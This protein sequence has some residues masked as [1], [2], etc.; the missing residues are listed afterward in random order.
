[1]MHSFTNIDLT[2]VFMCFDDQDPPADLES[3]HSPPARYCGSVEK[4]CIFG[5]C[6]STLQT[7]Q[8]LQNLHHSQSKIQDLNPIISSKF[9]DLNP[10]ISYSSLIS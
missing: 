6:I 8:T 10:L 3:N 1:M 5:W 4:D 9:L 2:S 7:L